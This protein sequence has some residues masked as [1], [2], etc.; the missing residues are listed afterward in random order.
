[1]PWYIFNPGNATPN[2]SNRNQY[3]MNGMTPPNCPG[4]RNICAIQSLDSGGLPI[5]TTVLLGE[6]I[7]ALET[8]NESANVSLKGT[9]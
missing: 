7:K 8:G 2:P 6:I 3:S 4:N 5:M 9:C 1:M